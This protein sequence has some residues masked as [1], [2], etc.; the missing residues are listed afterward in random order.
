MKK[1][2]LIAL[3]ATITWSCTN[4]KGFIINGTIKGLN[5]KKVYLKRFADKILITTDS[6]IIK[7]NHFRFKG[8]VESPD[9]YG[10]FFKGIQRGVF[11]LIEN[12]KINI[13]ANKDSLYKAKFIGSKVNDELI[14]FK[15]SSRKIMTQNNT[16]YKDFEKARQTNDTI[17]LAKIKQALHKIREENLH[18]ALNY[19]KQ[20]P[21]SYIS[22]IALD[23]LNHIN[24]I[25]KDTIIKIYNNFS[26]KVKENKFAKKIANSLNIPKK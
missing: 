14:R 4:N 18:Y 17:E 20:H 5:G 10:V 13:I 2:F 23:A 15:D 21:N 25:S 26:D 7:K 1:I 12:S 6:T 22:P 11:G 8:K 19:A 16:F 9:F 3:L 24:S